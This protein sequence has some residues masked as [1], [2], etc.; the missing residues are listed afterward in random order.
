MWTLLWT[1]YGGTSYKYEFASCEE[2]ELWISKERNVLHWQIWDMTKQQVVV[3]M[4]Y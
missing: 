4:E 3:E 2:A 1:T